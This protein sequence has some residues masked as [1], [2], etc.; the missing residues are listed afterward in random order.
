MQ[1][2][3]TVA[4]LNVQLPVVVDVNAPEVVTIRYVAGPMRQAADAAPPGAG[5]GAGA[6][7]GDGEGVLLPPEPLVLGEVGD[8][9]PQAVAAARLTTTT[10][11]AFLK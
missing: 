4:A 11:T 7:A 6:G 2:P 8:E 5:A 9:P 1:V 10:P 3:S